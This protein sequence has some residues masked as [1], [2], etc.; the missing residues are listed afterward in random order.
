MF[1]NNERL[2]T[3]LSTG[4]PQ[5]R[6]IY[7][8]F[9]HFGSNDTTKAAI[10]SLLSGSTRPDSII[11]VDHAE[12]AFAYGDN[13]VIVI[14]PEINTGYFGGLQT[15]ITHAVA[16]GAKNNDL[17]ILLNNDVVFARDS[18]ES[19]SHWW[20][21]YGNVNTLAG[22]SLGAVSLLSGRARIMSEQQISSSLGTIPYVH[23]SCM[24]GEVGLFTSI[25]FPTSLFLYWED[26]LL[27]MLVCKAGGSL[28]AIPGLQPIHDDQSSP[29]SPTKLYY[30]V[31]NGAYVLEVYTP[32]LWRLYWFILNTIRKA[33]HANMAG[34]KHAMVKRAL[35]DARSCIL[36]K[37][38]I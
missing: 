5:R 8:I 26:V 32:V 15:G 13:G 27:S 7:A 23:G 34:D 2:S 20:S 36:G 33:Y 3:V 21:S 28:R 37:A 14:R 17:C 9:V 10:D 18:L 29:V 4:I 25:E 22:A 6:S 1:T 35:R 16:L 11:V 38:N 19:I 31:R 24:V 30:M 12:S